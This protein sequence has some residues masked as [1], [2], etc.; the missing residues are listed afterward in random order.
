[1]MIL[2]HQIKLYLY[3]EPHSIGNLE[4][5]FLE[6]YNSVDGKLRQTCAFQNIRCVNCDKNDKLTLYKLRRLLYE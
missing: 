3:R 4:L 5:E 2:D 1:M 6:A